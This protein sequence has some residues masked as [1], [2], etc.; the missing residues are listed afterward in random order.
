M[1]LE[2]EF[3]RRTSAEPAGKTVRRHVAD[4]PSQ[5]ESESYGL[6]NRPDEADGFRIYDTGILRKTISVRPETHDA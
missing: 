2:I 6:S 3:F 4:F 5:K 1:L